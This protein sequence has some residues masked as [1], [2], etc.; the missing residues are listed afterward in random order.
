LY[1]QRSS[2][3]CA[4]ELSINRNSITM[5]SV[6]PSS[7][8]RLKLRIRHLFYALTLVAGCL[9]FPFEAFWG[10]QVVSFCLFLANMI[11]LFWLLLDG[12]RRMPRPVKLAV[13][14]AY[15]IGP[16][17]VVCWVI[18]VGWNLQYDS[19]SRGTIVLS[20]HAIGK[21]FS[22]QAPQRSG[23]SISRSTSKVVRLSPGGASLTPSYEPILETHQYFPFIV[24]VALSGLLLLLNHSSTIQLTLG[25][26]GRKL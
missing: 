7:E 19:P 6:N 17:A 12:G 9:A 3:R 1:S 24:P 11:A 14:M 25:C 8:H 26:F 16:I 4:D 5:A 15:F 23:W 13:T 18:S 22:S 20:E 21:L 10:L 2:G